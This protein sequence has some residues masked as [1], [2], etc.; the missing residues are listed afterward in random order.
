[1]RKVVVVVAAAAG[2]SKRHGYQLLL[3]SETSSLLNGFFMWPFFCPLFRDGVPHRPLY[4]AVY[5][6]GPL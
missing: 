6:L 5:T 2:C 1:M 4:K 3:A